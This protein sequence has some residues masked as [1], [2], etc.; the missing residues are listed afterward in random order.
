MIERDLCQVSEV[1][2]YGAFTDYLLVSSVN[3]ALLEDFIL[4]S[5]DC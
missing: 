3:P 2:I 1:S 5:L 4:Y